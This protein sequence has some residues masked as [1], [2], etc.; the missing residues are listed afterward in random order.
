MNSHDFMPVW[1]LLLSGTINNLLICN[2]ALLMRFS[3]IVAILMIAFSG[4]VLSADAIQLDVAKPNF[5]VQQ[6]NILNAVNTNVEYSEISI[7][8]RSD[9]TTALGRIAE[10]LMLGDFVSLSE[11]DRNKVL[12]DQVLINAG[13]TQAMQDSRLV[14]RREAVLGTN[15]TKKVCRTYASLKKENDKIR[16]E[17]TTGAKQL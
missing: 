7:K 10:K 15:F 5:Q 1:E 3:V 13:L 14:C 4:S 16:D 12:Q 17:R 9:L 11:E 2:G 8:D 6:K